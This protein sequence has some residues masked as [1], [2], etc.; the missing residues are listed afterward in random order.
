MTNRVQ[1]APPHCSAVSICHGVPRCARDWPGLACGL[2]RAT[3]LSKAANGAVDVRH[4][5]TSSRARAA[6][7]DRAAASRARVDGDRRATLF[8]FAAWSP[9]ERPRGRRPP[10][11]PRD[12]LRRDARALRPGGARGRH[13]PRD[14][15]RPRQLRPHLRGD[16]RDPAARRRDAPPSCGAAARHARASPTPRST[17]PTPP[18]AAVVD[19]VRETRP[20]L[21]I[22]HHRRLHGRPQR[23]LEAGLRLQLPRDAA[24]ATRPAGRTTTRDPDLLH[25]HDHGPRL[26][27]DGV[28]R[29]V[30][31][32]RDEGGDARGAREPAHVAARP[33]RHRHRRAD[34]RGDALPGAAVRSRGTRRD[35][36]RA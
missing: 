26:P 32:D 13:V 17:P 11:R 3:G 27:A 8:D 33:R 23:D 10:G 9:R 35:S 34:A 28:R 16:R 1:P 2:A 20:D 30:G 19:L 5:R 25:G 36:C 4:E 15:R 22:T 18:S 14:P 6:A 29:R 21:I 7:V 31:R 12:P 24:A